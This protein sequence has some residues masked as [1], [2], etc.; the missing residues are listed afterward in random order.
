MSPAIVRNQLHG[1][2]GT[3][4]LLWTLFGVGAVATLPLSPLPARRRPGV[5]N[6]CG[7]LAWGPAML[8]IAVVDDVAVATLLFLLGS[9]LGPVHGR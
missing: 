1:D 9:H 2:E 7:A 8:L 4:S 5:A 3:Y 6:A